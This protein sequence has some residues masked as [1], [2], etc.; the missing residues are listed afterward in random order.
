MAMSRSS[1]IAGSD[2]PRMDCFADST[3]CPPRH[4]VR[5]TVPQTF[6]FARNRIEQPLYADVTYTRSVFSISLA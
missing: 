3:S 2:L 5:I 6:S 4:K 1:K